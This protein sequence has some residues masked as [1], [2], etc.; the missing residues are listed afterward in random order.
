MADS[1]GGVVTAGL[2]LMIAGLAFPPQSPRS[3]E[4]V[5]IQRAPISGVTRG[6]GGEFQKAWALVFTLEKS[7]LSSGYMHSGSNLNFSVSSSPERERHAIC[8][9][10]SSENEGEKKY[11]KRCKAHPLES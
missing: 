11:R 1:L 10:V 7:F 6:V 4:G 3:R 8:V 9:L 5:R 2:G